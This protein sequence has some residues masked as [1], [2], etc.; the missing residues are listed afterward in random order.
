MYN[1]TDIYGTFP[2]TSR[3]T[4]TGWHHNNTSNCTLTG[5]GWHHNNTS[6]CTLTHLHHHHCQQQQHSGLIATRFNPFRGEKLTTCLKKWF[7]Q[8]DI[9]RLLSCWS[10][11]QSYT[12]Q[13]ENWLIDWVR[14]NVPPTHYRSYRGWVFTGQMTQPTVSKKRTWAKWH[15]TSLHVSHQESHIYRC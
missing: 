10:N 14:L 4:G 13:E 2:E 3:W 7:L 9:S 6:N 5:T 15:V 1:T 8:I 11:M 12:N